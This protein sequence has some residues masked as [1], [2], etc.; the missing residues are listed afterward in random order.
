MYIEIPTSID[1]EII[2]TEAENGFGLEDDVVEVLVKRRGCLVVKSTKC[3]LEAYVLFSMSICESTTKPIAYVV[4]IGYNNVYAGKMLVRHLRVSFAN[5]GYSSACLKRIG[6]SIDSEWGSIPATSEHFAVS[7]KPADYYFNKD[8]LSMYEDINEFSEKFNQ[9][10][11]DRDHYI[12]KDL[13]SIQEDIMDE[14]TEVHKGIYKTKLFSKDY[15]SYLVDKIKAFE[16]ETN[17][18]EDMY[19]QIPEVVI[20]FNDSETYLELEQLFTDY[21]SKYMEALRFKKHFE[22]NSIQF[23]RYSASSEISKGNWHY[24]SDSDSTVVVYLNDDYSGGGTIFKPQGTAD[25]VAVDKFEV[26]DSIFFNGKTMPHKG[27]PVT[28]GDRYILVFWCNGLEG[29]C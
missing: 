29:D 6:F 16:F 21:I 15:C 17:S 19:Y 24:D 27:L 23:A 1:K 10:L 5:V 12:T 9:L 28:E 4:A 20:K 3:T 14:V 2:S 18:E 25:E 11:P 8:F 22:I 13:Q 7:T 26:G